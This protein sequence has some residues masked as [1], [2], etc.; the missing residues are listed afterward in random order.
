MDYVIFEQNV[1]DKVSKEIQREIDGKAL[2]IHNLAVLTEQDI[3]QG[4]DYFSLMKQNLEVL[5]TATD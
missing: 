2:Q 3:N 4:E 1:Q 5:K